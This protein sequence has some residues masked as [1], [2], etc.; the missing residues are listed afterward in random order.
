MPDGSYTAI[1]QGLRRVD[2]EAVVETVPYLKA[3][4][5]MREETNTDTDT[6]EFAVILTN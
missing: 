5:V 6:S 2:I 4:V 1:L 3:S